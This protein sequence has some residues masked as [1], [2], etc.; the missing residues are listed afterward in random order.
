MQIYL[1]HCHYQIEG[2]IVMAQFYYTIYH[3]HAVH[4]S[5]SLQD[6]QVV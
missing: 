3:G 4:V 1:V 5:G 6:R 2:R